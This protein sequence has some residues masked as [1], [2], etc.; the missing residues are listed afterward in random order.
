MVDITRID[1]ITRKDKASDKKPYY[2]DFYTNFNVHP[3]N[4]K[5]AKYTNEEAVKRSVRNLI[6]TDKND[7][8]FHPELGCKVRNLLFENMSEIV[9]DEIRSTIR[10]TVETYEPRA[11]IIDIVVQ[12]ND[13]RQS[14]DVYI[15]FNVINS[16]EPVSVNITLYRA[17]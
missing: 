7:R 5:L 13:A 2:S 17:R 12:A 6:Q 16:I 15:Y 9:V 8:L 3:Q 4:N 11:R 14:Y 1:R 10:E